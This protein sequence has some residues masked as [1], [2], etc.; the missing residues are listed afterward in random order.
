MMEYVA[1]ALEDPPQAR[2]KTQQTPK[3]EAQ[4]P[5]GDPP[6]LLHSELV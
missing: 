4:V 6:K 1:L 3:L 5:E 2:E